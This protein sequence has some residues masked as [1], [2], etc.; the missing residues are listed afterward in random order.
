MKTIGPCGHL[1]DTN[2]DADI[3]RHGQVVFDGFQFG[4]TVRFHKTYLHVA[5]R[6]G[7]CLLYG[8]TQPLTKDNRRCE[9]CNRGDH[10]AC[11]PVL[12]CDCACAMSVSS[13]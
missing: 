4:D 10:G 6:C 1:H 8:N 7:W 5:E 2:D 3:C 12:G 13:R 11:R 9:A